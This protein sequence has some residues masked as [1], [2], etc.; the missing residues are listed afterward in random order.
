MITDLIDADE[1]ASGKRKESLY[2]AVWK[3]VLK[4]ARAVAFVVIGV[5]LDLVGLDLSR[6][7]VSE[8]AQWGIVLLFGIVVGLCFIVA[9]WFIKRA[10]VPEP[11]EN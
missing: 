8:G 11:I 10:D 3:S 5:G 7:T 9:G 6:E 2:F 1:V 4:I